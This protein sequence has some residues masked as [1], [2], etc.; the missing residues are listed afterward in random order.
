MKLFTY[1]LKINLGIPE[2]K[3]ALSCYLMKVFSVGI[4]TTNIGN[5]N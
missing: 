3:W 2:F 5:S 1:I 4:L